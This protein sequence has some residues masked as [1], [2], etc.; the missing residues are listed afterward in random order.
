MVRRKRA[1]TGQ[2]RRAEEGEKGTAHQPLLPAS[3]QE[4]SIQAWGQRNP[5]PPTFPSSLPLVRAAA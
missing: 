3:A 5:E 4:H 2:G 1:Q